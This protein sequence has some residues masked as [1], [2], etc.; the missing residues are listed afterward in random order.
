MDPRENRI[1]LFSVFDACNLRCT[2]CH[3]FSAE[4]VPQNRGIR[5]RDIV[6]FLS[7]TG[8]YDRA[9]FSGGEPTLWP[10]LA[11]AVNGAPT[12]TQEVGIYTHGGFPGALA[13]I[14]R[15]GLYLRLSLHKETDWPA[16][17]ETLTLAKRRGWKVKVFSYETDY[18][19]VEAP[20]WF[21]LPVKVNPDQLK[22]GDDVLSHL[23]G[24]LVRCR[25]RMLFSAQTVAPTP[26]KRVCARRTTRSRSPLTS[27]RER[28]V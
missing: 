12:S 5:A 16:F 8:P 9:V 19:Q 22:A 14:R 4:V 24:A 27:G 3:W 28:R 18:A 21:D 1:V 20:P 15:E 2:N 23:I 26:A 11:E 10:E 25:P 17:R 13:P 6:S 7:R